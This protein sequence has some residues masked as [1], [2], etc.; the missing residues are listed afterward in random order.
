M[1]VL[2]YDKDLKIIHE[3]T[4][5]RRN[6]HDLRYRVLPKNKA[7][8]WPSVSRIKTFASLSEDDDEESESNAGRSPA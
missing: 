5:T 6:E 7:R 8:L 4:G 1:A 2:Y 3:I